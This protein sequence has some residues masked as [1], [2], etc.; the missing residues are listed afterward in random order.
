MLMTAL[1]RLNRNHPRQFDAVAD[2][3]DR[4]SDPR[5]RRASRLAGRVCSM[6]G[7]VSGRA[8]DHD[9]RFAADPSA[10]TRS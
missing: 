7:R 10:P 8:G 6:F 1:D 4:V 3:F 9:P 2:I 5:T